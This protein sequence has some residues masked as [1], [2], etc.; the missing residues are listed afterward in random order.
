MTHLFT[1]A[2]RFHPLVHEDVGLT[3]Q[4]LLV[5]AGGDVIFSKVR[6]V[7]CLV[8][9]GS[10]RRS[11]TQQTQQHIPPLMRGV[12]RQAMRQDMQASQKLGY[13]Q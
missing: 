7:W 8:S 9:S 5:D 1:V 4:G 11:H 2:S 6:Q 10:A 3:G 12:E 13:Y